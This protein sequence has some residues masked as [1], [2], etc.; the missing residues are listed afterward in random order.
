MTTPV[1]GAFM[2]FLIFKVFF[3]KKANW[4]LIR[5]DMILDN[6]YLYDI[7]TEGKYPERKTPVARRAK[8]YL[9]ENF[10]VCRQLCQQTDGKWRT[11]FP[12]WEKW[13]G[14]GIRHSDGDHRESATG[15]TGGTSDP[16][17]RILD[18][19]GNCLLPVVLRK[20]L[21]GNSESNYL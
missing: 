17:Q 16:L 2:N 6:R 21:H 18:W 15:C 10:A 11:E 3:R 13:R 9:V 5:D 1:I 20:N 7:L 12:C 4:Q 19:L 8:R 14:Y